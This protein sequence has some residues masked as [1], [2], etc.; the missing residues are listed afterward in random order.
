MAHRK[1]IYQDFNTRRIKLLLILVFSWDLMTIRKCPVSYC[2]SEGSEYVLHHQF[3]NKG[4]D[5]KKN[6]NKGATG[7]RKE[8]QWASEPVSKSERERVSISEH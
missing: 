3:K 4:A 6:K 8:V 2:L 1:K 5:T 7:K